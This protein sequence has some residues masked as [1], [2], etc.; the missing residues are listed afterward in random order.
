[1]SCRSNRSAFAGIELDRSYR[2]QWQLRQSTTL[3]K[4][5][6]LATEPTTSKARFAPIWRAVL[7]VATSYRIK[8]SL[9]S[10]ISV[11]VLPPPKVSPSQYLCQRRRYAGR[12]KERVGS[13]REG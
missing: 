5:M 12:L 11:P 4:D 8:S 9:Y 1:M 6:L 10:P 2:A 3:G 7:G 13:A